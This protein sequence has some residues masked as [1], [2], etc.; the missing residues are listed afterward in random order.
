MP[1]IVNRNHHDHPLM[2]DGEEVL[3]QITRMG[4][5]AF[6]EF[7]ATFQ[8]IAERRDAVKPDLAAMTPEAR[9]EWE[10]T[11]KDEEDEALEF[12]QGAVRTWVAVAPGQIV[13]DA[14]IDIRTGQELLDLYGTRHDVMFELLSAIW[15]THKLSPAQ[16]KALRSRLASGA[17]S[18]AHVPSPD[19]ASPAPTAAE[20]VAPEDGTAS[21]T[22]AA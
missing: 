20:P 11:D 8:R 22:V 14:N 3:L 7:S 15:L 10:R 9:A 18:A 1:I 21:G 19:G 6:E 5:R 13:D 17:T 12:L 2:L 16:K 4:F